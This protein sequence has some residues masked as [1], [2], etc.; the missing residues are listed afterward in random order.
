MLNF[1]EHSGGM[2]LYYVLS[3]LLNSFLRAEYFSE[4]TLLFIDYRAFLVF[5]EIEISCN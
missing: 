4:K 5:Y 3:T 2:H 1:A